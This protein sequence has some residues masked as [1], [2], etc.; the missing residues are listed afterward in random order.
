MIKH[1]VALKL[2]RVF[3]FVSLLNPLM[4]KNANADFLLGAELGGQYPAVMGNIAQNFN[5]SFG[6]HASAYITPFISDDLEHYI[7]VGF[8]NLAFK[9]DTNANFRI[10]PILFGLSLPGKTPIEGVYADFGLA[11]GGALDWVS[12]PNLAS[13]R[14]GGHFA[15]QLQPGLSI[16]LAEDFDLYARTPVFYLIG[17]RQMSFIAYDVGVKMRF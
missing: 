13:W 4:P 15:V 9:T 3:L 7:Y 8:Q 17:Q 10:V 1:H 14:I 6:F 12:V 5:P 2:L 11:L 16:S